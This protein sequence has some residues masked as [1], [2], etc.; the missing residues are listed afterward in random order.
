MLTAVL[1]EHNGLCIA[2]NTVIDPSRPHKNKTAIVSHAHT[3][4]C[5]VHTTNSTVATPE[6]LALMKLKGINVVKQKAVGLKK[7]LKLEELRVSF[8]HAGHILGSAQ[9]LLE[10]AD[11]WNAAI[12][13]DFKLQNSILFEGA[14]ILEADTLVME[15]TFGNPSYSFPERETVYENMER[16]C[17]KQLASNRL[18]VLAGYAVGKAQELTAFV[19]EYL[20]IEPHVTEPIW[21]ANR[22]YE[23]FGI[24]LGGYLPLNGD[25]RDASVLI[26]PPH[27]CS[28]AL[29]E[30]IGISARRPIASAMATGWPHKGCFE[31]CFPLSDHADFNQLVEYVTQSRPKLVLTTH[32][33]AE[34]L[35]TLLKRKVG[36]EATPLSAYANMQKRLYDFPR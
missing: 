6:T 1:S 13:S 18:V 23:S 14:E 35:A 30:A 33:F 16:W 17:K 28:Q 26:V 22:I 25:M 15:S 32:G 5:K 2:T 7:R 3:D 10:H 34:E 24:K 11:G 36:V 12:T 4:H 21:E 29:L 19:N 27:I 9:I 31:R 8:H 20:G